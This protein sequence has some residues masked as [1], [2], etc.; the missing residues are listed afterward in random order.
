MNRHMFIKL[1]A[2]SHFEQRRLG[3]CSYRLFS[4]HGLHPQPSVGF[5]ESLKC[6]DAMPV[7]QIDRR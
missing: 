4:V 5:R 1:R 2:E 7:G 3:G 6:D